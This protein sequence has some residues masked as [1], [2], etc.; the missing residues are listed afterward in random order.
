[1]IRKR[2]EHARDAAVEATLIDAQ[3]SNIVP[4]RRSFKPHDRESPRAFI[5][6]P[7]SIDI[8]PVT[9]RQRRIQLLAY[10]NAHPHELKAV[11]RAIA[12]VDRRFG[13]SWN[14]DRI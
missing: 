7:T 8:D 12:T 6:D 13:M 11:E 3:P 1:L 9:Y 4:I 5:D 10:A 14:F 2:D